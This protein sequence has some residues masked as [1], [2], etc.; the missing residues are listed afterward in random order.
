MNNDPRPKKLQEVNIA[1]KKDDRKIWKLDLPVIEMPIDDLMW[2][3]DYP[4]WEKEG[5]DDWNL[6]PQELV[7]DP[8]K[9]PTHYRK[10]QRA[11]L[12]FPL[13]VMRHKGRW[14]LLDGMHRLVKAY[15]KGDKMVKVRIIP[16]SVIALIKTGRWSDG[17]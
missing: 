7:D 17:Y 8:K 14:L 5:T 15:L 1:F 6:T 2:H 11:D 4:W 13:Q 16:P 3:F 12:A 10:I 9:E